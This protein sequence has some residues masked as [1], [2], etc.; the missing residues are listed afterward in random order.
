MAHSS[1]GGATKRPSS[2]ITPSPKKS[3]DTTGTMGSVDAKVVP[4]Q[5]SNAL[6][7]ICSSASASATSVSDHIPYRRPKA[8]TSVGQTSHTQLL[9]DPLEPLSKGFAEIAS[10]SGSLSL[11]PADDSTESH[12]AS[13]T[14]GVRKK[15]SMNNVFNDSG[16]YSQ[17]DI[18]QSELERELQRQSSIF[19]VTG[20]VVPAAASHSATRAGRG[21][22]M[23]HYSGKFLSTSDFNSIKKSQRGQRRMWSSDW[24]FPGQDAGTTKDVFNR[25]AIARVVDWNCLGVLGCVRG[26][27]CSQLQSAD[28]LELRR[29]FRA[30][31]EG[32]RIFYIIKATHC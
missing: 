17:H 2:G 13:F 15:L 18:S 23:L 20:D 9:T 3:D 6:V 7:P 25:I 22:I 11:V 26:D 21:R 16:S 32:R 19:R 29:L 27:C 8:R 12:A 10:P 30:R 31:C 28:V 4:E 14:G 24:A 5:T 1:G